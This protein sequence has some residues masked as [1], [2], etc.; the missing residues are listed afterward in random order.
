MN[1]QLDPKSNFEKILSFTSKIRSEKVEAL[2]L[3]EYF[4][5]MSAEGATPFVVGPDTDPDDNPSLAAICNLAKT[6]KVYLVGGSA[7]T[8]DHAGR[9]VNRAYIIAPDGKVLDF[10]D[11]MNL[12]ECNLGE[13]G[14]YDETKFFTP[15][16]EQKVLTL[17]GHEE[18]NKGMSL[19]YDLRFPEHF[20]DMSKKE[21]SGGSANLFS[22]SSAFTAHTGKAHWHL[23]IRVRAI[24]NQAYVVAAA[25]CGTHVRD[26]GNGRV[27][28]K[29][30]YGHSMIVDP[31]GEVLVDAGGDQE[32]VFACDVKKEIIDEVRSRMKVL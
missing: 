1:S 30:T 10:Y 13:K 4:Y 3:P 18:F 31:W 21:A 11:K 14:I 26:L 12:F 25:Q 5:S 27:V 20:R 32:G 7:V 24:E 17:P 2:F 28:S 19:C 22:I 23:L 16:H 8:R 9:F 6:L 15:G 29:Q